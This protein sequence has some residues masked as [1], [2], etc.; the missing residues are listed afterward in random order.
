MG[1]KPLAAAVLVLTVVACG[2]APGAE[3][4]ITVEIL[5]HVTEAVLTAV[6]RA[7]CLSGTAALDGRT[8]LIERPRLAAVLEANRDGAC[9]ERSPALGIGLYHLAGGEIG[10]VRVDWDADGVAQPSADASRRY[11]ACVTIERLVEEPG[12]RLVFNFAP[13]G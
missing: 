11:N 13:C 10:A 5:N 1:R 3:S 2:P 8:V 4:R 6:D 12:P 7:D 9:A